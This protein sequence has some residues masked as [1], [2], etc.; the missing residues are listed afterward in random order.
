MAELEAKVAAQDRHTLIELGLP[1]VRRVAF[2]LARRL[3]PNVDV[4]DLIGAGSEGLLRAIDKFDHER[5]TRFEPY[6]EARI[7]G[8]IL[9][10][11]RA[12]DSMTRHGRRRLAEVTRTIRKLEQRLGRA[13]EEEEIARE[14]GMPL[15]AYRKLAEDLARGPALARLGELHPDDLE[16]HDGGADKLHAEREMKQLLAK[17]I[18]R[19]PERT[20]MV[21]ALYYQEE[22][23]QA[24]IGTILGITESRVCQILGES[25]A[26][27]R[28][29][30]AKE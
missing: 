6:A 9:D 2:R 7:R 26:R 23:T 29:Q 15:D 20:Q 22:C 13:A 1:I 24:E 17:A 12:S 14:L 19:L 28:A 18:A 16:S 4:G 27:L 5:Y 30:L 10:E 25:A 8:A 3:P 11:L 21:L